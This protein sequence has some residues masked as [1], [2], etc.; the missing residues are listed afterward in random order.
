MKAALI[1]DFAGYNSDVV[2]REATSSPAFHWVGDL[3]LQCTLEVASDEG[4]AV[5]ELVKGGRRFQ[6]RFDVQTGDA[7]LSIGGK[8]SFQLDGQVYEF[9]PTAKTKV[10]GKGTHEVLFAN[11]DQQLRLW[12]DG[13]EVAFDGPTGYPPLNNLRP[14]A[15]D[16]APAGVGSSGGRPA[17]QP[18][19]D[20]ARRVL[21]D[22]HADQQDAPR[23]DRPAPDEHIEGAGFQAEQLCNWWECAAAIDPQMHAD[24][25]L[26]ADQFFMMGDNSPRSK[27]ARCWDAERYVERDLLIGKAFFIYWPHS[28]DRPVPFWPN[29]RRM[30]FVR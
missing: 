28:W 23:A 17:G 16:M 30:G 22:L 3:A 8:G 10:C 9:A 21:H 14:A 1:S 20:P 26:D 6:C 7:T 12:V 29:F 11:C 19:E 15:A 13:R 18:L 2:G 4:Q 27:D 25:P 5:L 24:Y